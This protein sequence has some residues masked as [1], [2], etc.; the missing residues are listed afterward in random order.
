M[1]DVLM[2]PYSRS[3]IYSN[4][5]INV[6]INKL[7]QYDEHFFNN[8]MAFRNAHGV[9][10]SGDYINAGLRRSFLSECIVQKADFTNAGFTDSKFYD[11]FFFGCKFDQA[12]LQFSNFYNCKIDSFEDKHTII[13][14]T[15]CDSGNYFMTEFNNVQINASSFTN[16]LFE[17]CKFQNCKIGSCTLENSIFKNTEI[18]DVNFE[19]LN[20][21]FADF[22]NVMFKDVTFPFFQVPYTFNGLSHIFNP[23]N[24][25]KIFADKAYIS[26]DE[27][28][29]A[30]GDLKIY[31]N[32][33]N[34]FFPLANI[35][36]QLGNFDNAMINIK[37]GIIFNI[38]M[39]NFRMLKFYCKLAV[40]NG[41]FSKI[42]LKKLYEDIQ[43][44]TMKEKL[45]DFEKRSFSQHNGELRDILI[46]NIYGM[47]T[48]ELVFQ[49]N[50]DSTDVT[51]VAKMIEYIDSTI[52]DVCVGEKS[53][54][55]EFSHN[56]LSQFIAFVSSNPES[57][58]L[59]LASFYALSKLTNAVQDFII[60]NQTIIEN[61]RNR[62]FT[63]QKQKELLEHGIN[64]ETNH[65]IVNITNN[66]NI[67]I[68]NV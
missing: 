19:R 38:A 67:Y 10:F 20:L 12:N 62:R 57:I 68:N 13:E 4:E 1:K 17:N 32:S 8:T 37:S 64:F 48:L 60:K 26:S 25:V 50:I 66:Q 27:Y 28:K 22:Q 58:T 44:F 9:T 63:K 42:Q 31:F 18:S 7:K 16:A 59:L 46:D 36:L 53:S 35:E 29:H 52:E 34:E 6:A 51:K 21:E 56:S 39:K 3:E 2:V 24:N 33:I 65:V 55:I 43:N 47:P 41:H 49:T 15:N 40:S 54:K 30:L 23:E 61:S 14:G 5:E 45:S 11:T